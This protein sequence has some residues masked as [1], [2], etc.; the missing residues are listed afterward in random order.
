LAE[1]GTVEEERGFFTLQDGARLCF[2]RHGSGPQLV[3][4]PGGP[5]LRDDLAPLLPG[6]TLLLYDLR[7]RGRSDAAFAPGEALG[8]LADVAD[9]EAVRRLLGVER[10][11]LLGHSYV[12]FVIGLYAARHAGRIERMVQIGPTGPVPS[13]VYEP[14]R[15]HA[16]ATSRAVFAGLAALLPRRAEFDDP[17]AF[18]RAFWDVLRPLY[19][20]DAKD[21]A[22][23]RWDRCELPNERA[24]FRYWT[25]VV[26]P[27]L[28]GL[29]VVRED[30]GAADAPAL[31]V[32]GRL[33][34]SAPF[35]GGEDWAEILP[36]ARLLAV[37]GAGHAPWIEAPE[38]VFGAISGFL[39]G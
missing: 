6:R 22:R 10:L 18:C 36:D 39:D 20:T 1:G 24:A 14:P 5:Y 30:V 32:H 38:T 34:R 19:V 2:E 21:A 16:D 15:S 17:A 33:D 7:H 31:V 37:P 23:I 26:Q 35:G 13:R 8:V 4:V 12:G 25:E 29:S 28:L 9:L 3:V 11:R 27:S